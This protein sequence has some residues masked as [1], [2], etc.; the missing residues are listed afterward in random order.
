MLKILNIESAKTTILRRDPAGL[1][2]Y[3]KALL[4][5]VA[6]IFGSGVTPAGAVEQILESVRDEGDSAMIR[7]TETLDKTSLE[8]MRIP[9]DKLAEADAALPVTLA[10]A[11]CLSAERIRDFHGPVRV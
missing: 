7:W 10:K 11:M 3:P 1:K 6:Q 9:E 5:G 4:D 2:D 8:C